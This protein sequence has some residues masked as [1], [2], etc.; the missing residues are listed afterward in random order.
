MNDA[1]A[2]HNACAPVAP[3]EETGMSRVINN[4]AL[5]LNQLGLY[6]VTVIGS[7]ITYD[8]EQKFRSLPELHSRKSK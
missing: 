1:S 4:N 7:R 5:K 8:T 6:L 3:V 2:R